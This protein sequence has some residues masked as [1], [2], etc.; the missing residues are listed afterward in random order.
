MNSRFIAATITLFLLSISL[1]ATTIPFR[2]VNKIIV[3]QA[4][5]NNISGYFILDSGTTSLVLNDCCFRGWPTAEKVQGIGGKEIDV[6]K[7]RATLFLGELKWSAIIAKLLPLDH[8]FRSKNIQIMGLIGM[9][10]LN[11]YVLQI[12]YK[13]LTLEIEREQDWPKAERIPDARFRFIWKG[14]IPVINTLLGEQALRFGID[15]GAGINVLNRSLTPKVW[16]NLDL[17]HQRR[18]IGLDGQSQIVSAGT[19]HR[20][21]IGEFFCP[22]MKVVLAP[23]EHF[24][25]SSSQ[26]NSVDGFIGYEFLHHFKTVFN[27]KR[28]TIA[29]YYNDEEAK[30]LIVAH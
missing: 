19:I 1:Q 17:N 12:D 24:K 21:I 30:E 11:R 2:L 8:L 22:E 9:D 27:F 5:V 13:N 18:V 3:V 15:T 10:I 26:F 28:R 20:L 16:S 14:G 6:Y 29:L 25:G 4:K 23:L 7:A